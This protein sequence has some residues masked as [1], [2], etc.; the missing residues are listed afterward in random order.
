[1]PH[2]HSFVHVLMQ[3]LSSDISRTFDKKLHQFLTDTS[4]PRERQQCVQLKQKARGGMGGA[5]V[6]DETTGQGNMGQGFGQG[7]DNSGSGIGKHARI[8]LCT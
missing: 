5:G 3:S 6:M 4:R 7:F 8:V 1:M 2:T